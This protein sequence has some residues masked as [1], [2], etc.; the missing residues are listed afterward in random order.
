MLFRVLSY[1]LVYL[2]VPVSASAADKIT[3]QLRWHHQFQFAGYYA[4]LE[5]GYYRDAGLDVTIV[6]GAPGREPVKEVLAGRAQYGEANSELLYERLNGKPLVAL[7]S[8]FQHSPSVLLVRE[9]SGIRS[10]QDLTGR[11]VMVI[12]NEADVDILAMMRNEGVDLNAVDL[13]KSSYNIND[14]VTGKTDAFNS[15]LTNEPY[16][17]EQMGIPVRVINPINYGVDFY[18]DVL[19]T[20]E[21]ELQNHPE[22]VRAFREASLRGWTYAM[23]H[24]SELIDLILE[25]YNSS[26]NRAH[27]EFEAQAME[28]LILPTL[29]EMGHM[30][31]GRWKHMAQTFVDEG[32]ITSTSRL[33]GF[34]YDPTLSAINQK[35]RWLVVGLLSVLAVVGGFAVLAFY[36][37]SRLKREVAV[38]T[39]ALSE[40]M[41]KAQVA[42]RAKSE[43]MANM[44]HEL[45]T[46]L[47]AIIGF[48][49]AMQLE[50]FGK[51]EGKYKEYAN[52]IAS[53]GE[54]L[55]ELI[56]D[57]LDVSAIEDNKAPL[58]ED[59]QD[60]ADVIDSALQIV[61]TF[62]EN[63]EITLIRKVEDGLPPMLADKRR[64]KQIMINLLSN[65][66]K[67]TLPGGQVMAT[68][69]IIDGRHVIVV[70][71]TGIGMDE[72]GLKKAMTKFGQ[73]DSGLNRK[74]EGTGLGLPLTKGLVELHGGT[75]EIGSQ[76]E[77]GTT[78][79]LT[80]PRERV[81]A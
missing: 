54:H 37:N 4:A 12:G 1:L 40:T 76:L 46:P 48:S 23:A 57:I 35:W 70:S 56:N 18:T 77:N 19:F 30:N 9:D 61:R 34:V 29:I 8:I 60:I 78:I 81:Y 39:Q 14:L 24:K 51:L 66:V 64:L 2:L 15:Y 32:L 7:A 20:T 74:Y 72:D 58:S 5:Q 28:A 80:F 68:A 63:G 31:P 43:L 11:K 42:N 27:L 44:S 55:L 21:S 45:R 67:F 3:M 17:M 41:E 47:N 6:N 73:V 65:A 16:F 36:F 59:S 38:Q 22:R 75:F 62:A 33:D 49:G 25:K 50:V 71:D 26:K 69:S 13:H 10:P 53:S 79:T 52:D